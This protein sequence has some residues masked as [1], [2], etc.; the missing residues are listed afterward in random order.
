MSSKVL[1][2]LLCTAWIVSAAAADGPAGWRTDGTGKYADADPVINWAPDAN[3]IWRTDLKGPSNAGPLILG[4]R[5]FVCREVDTLL[6]LNA[7]SGELLWEKATPLEDVFTDEQRTEAQAQAAEYDRLRGQL[8]AIEEKRKPLDREWKRLSGELKNTPPGLDIKRKL[9]AVGETVR[10]VD[11]RKKELQAQKAKLAEQLKAATQDAQ[12]QARLEELNRQIPNLEE[13]KRQ[14]EV[15]SKQLD[16]E[17]K[18]AP[19]VPEIKK[20]MDELKPGLD[21]MSAEAKKL[22]EGMQA[23]STYRRAGTNDVNGYSSPTPATDGRNVYV[24]FGT[25]VAACYDLE[26]NRKWARVVE[27]PTH[28]YGHSASPLLIGG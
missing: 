16:E 22:Q 2:S 21:Q 3:V 28:G 7:G 10:A 15:R 9:A 20:Q 8:K 18:K 12:G 5:I 1:L 26:G 4:D 19:D 17:L 6:C 23:N 25:G 27:K 13:G 14:L 24:L 11:G